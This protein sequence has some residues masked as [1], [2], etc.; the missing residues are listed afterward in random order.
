[1]LLFRTGRALTILGVIIALLLA[2][3]V[4]V[5]YLQ[6]C[7]RQQHLLS[8]RRQTHTTI[9]VVARRGS[10]YDRNGHE[11]AGT[12][13]TAGVYIDPAFMLRHYQQ[14]GRNLNQ[15]DMDL[16]RLATILDCRTDDLVRLISENAG[17]RYIRVAEHMSDRVAEAVTALNLPGVGV[18]PMCA[19]VYP[20][21]SLAAH[22]LGTVGADGQGL[23]GVEL[24]YHRELAG[25][26]G[27]RRVEKDARRRPIS[28]AAD[29]FVLPQ[30]GG[31]IMLTLDAAI[32]SIVEEELAEACRTFRAPR[33]E[34]VVINP[35]TGEVLALANWPT[36]H[37][38]N[39]GDSTAEM[40]LNRSV[41][42]PYEPGSAIKPFIMGP[43]LAWNVTRPEE[44]WP[45]PAITYVTPYGRRVTDV[46]F[47]GR[48]C[49]WDVLVKSS[50]IGMAM[51]SARMGNASLHRALRSF[52][53]GQVTGIELPGEDEGRLNPLPRWTRYSTESVAQG[54]ELMV[55]P[56]QLA[57]AFSVFANGGRLIKPR[58]VLGRI[59][60]RGDL[61][62]DPR[63]AGA[64]S[65]C[66]Q[67]I[68]EQTAALMRRIMA[69]VVVR[70]TGTKA[71]S[72][73]WNF[74]GKTG[75][76]HVSRGRAGYAS[77]LF[78]STFI[79]GAPLEN[80]RVVIA[81]TIHEPD[82]RLGHYGGTVSAP[83][84][85]RILQRTLEYL[86]VPPSPPLSM[87]PPQVIAVL[88]NFRAE[89]YQ[90]PRA[91]AE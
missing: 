16:A 85:G 79:A 74:F 44:L 19:R 91:S 63:S 29:D 26:D 20:M 84:A 61:V 15:M 67:V 41:V 3:M 70:G 51:L 28:I 33:G 89:L 69:D 42:V 22:V 27:W 88:H 64:A 78:N 50:N 86:Q 13:Q 48:L 58:I 14:N 38:Q 10:I 90:Q 81:M 66:P 53:F 8:A 52:G 23:E 73:Y 34:A 45:I 4:R 68:D 62:P 2:L 18:E 1:M 46:H 59:D 9:R 76:A 40:R 54:Y 30:H 87:P 31:H 47:Y 21:G 57:R 82:R 43:A 55:T 36:F 83:A 35:H 49:T 6:T 24:R 65:S 17:E 12:I 80:P 71:R 56:V 39:L 75:T 11:L 77:D 7:F 72:P 25:R 60:A 32:Q 37:P 5:A